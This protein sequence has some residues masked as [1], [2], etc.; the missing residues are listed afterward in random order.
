MRREPATTKRDKERI[1][2]DAAVKVIKE[3]GFHKARMSDIA[4]EAGISYGLVY[5][6][7]GNK[8]D[9]FDA[10]LNRW[11]DDLFEVLNELRKTAEEEVS[12]KLRRIIF[13][14]LDSYQERPGLV[15]I[16]ITQISRSTPNL[17][18]SRLARFQTFMSL[19]EEIMSEGQARQ[20]L[21]A[22]FRARYLT[23]IFLGALETFVSAMVLAEQKIHGQA[24]KQRIADCILEVFLNGA[25]NAGKRAGG[26]SPP[27]NLPGA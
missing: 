13:Y 23:Y 17:T 20:M 5:H 24:Q 15:S 22:D 18:P 9:L 2:W 19:T 26:E 8:Q 7:Y 6:Y 3:N 1:I 12:A 21:R 14:F 10:V 4:R 27:Q 25:R 16:F 11:W